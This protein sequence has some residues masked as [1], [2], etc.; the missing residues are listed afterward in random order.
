MFLLV[1][2]ETARVLFLLS[3]RRSADTDVEKLS[4]EGQKHARGIISTKVLV[5][6]SISLV[7]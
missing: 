7:K 4:R 6:Q 2:G 5:N 1:F 3:E